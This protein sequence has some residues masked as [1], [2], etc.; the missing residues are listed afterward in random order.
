ML[1]PPPGTALRDRRSNLESE[2]GQRQADLEALRAKITDVQGVGAKLDA[3]RA[4]LQSNQEA[5]RKALAEKASAEFERDAGEERNG[6][7]GGQR[8]R[9]SSVSALQDQQTKLKSDID[10]L[11]EA[12]SDG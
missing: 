11:N 7:L 4:E 5:A 1:K 9:R 8:E 3:Q 12:Q 10:Q 6:S 2:I